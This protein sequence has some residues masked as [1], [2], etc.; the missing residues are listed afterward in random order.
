MNQTEFSPASEVLERLRR[1]ARERLKDSQADLFLPFLDRYYGRIDAADLVARSLPDLFGVAFAHLRLGMARRRGETRLAVYSPNYDEHGFAVPH[2]VIEI[3]TDDMP[4]LVDSVTMELRRHRLGLHAVI[5]PVV[6]VRRG[7]DGELLEVLAEPGGTKPAD[8]AVILESFHHIEVDRQTE[9][10]VLEQLRDDLARVLGDVRAAVADWPVMLDRA[11]SLA[12]ELDSVDAADPDR[13]EIAEFLRWLIDGSFTFLGYREYEVVAVNGDQLLRAVPGTG[14]GV[15]RETSGQPRPHRL[16]TMPPEVRDKI[17]E[18]SLLNLTKTRSLATVHRSRYLDYVGVKRRDS[19]GTA[20]GEARFLGLYTTRVYKQWPSNIPI[21][22]RKVQAVLERAAHPADSHDGKAMVEILDSYP[23]DEL[24]QC[25]EDDLYTDARA[26]LAMR[27]RPRLRLR[28]R[29]DVF[30]RFYSCFVDLP[31]GKLTPAV[32]E[33]IRDALMT[34]LH[35]VHSEESTLLTDAVLARLH[36]VIYAEPGTAPDVDFV[37]I[38]RRIAAALRDWSDDLTD[39]LVEEFGEERGLLLLQRYAGAFPPGYRSDFPARMAVGDIRRI[40]ELA[41]DAGGRRL[42]MHLYRPLESLAGEPRLTLYRCGEPLT[43]SDVLPMLENMGMQVIDQRPYEVRPAGGTSV[44]IYDYGLRWEDDLDLDSGDIRERLPHALAAVWRGDAE[45]DRF[46]RLVLRAG[47]RAHEVTVLRAYAKYL[48][49]TGTTFSQRFM[50]DALAGNPSIVRGLVDLVWTRFDPDLDPGIDRE[51]GEK[52]LVADIVRGIDAVASLNEDRVLR[53]LLGL[54]MATLRTNL[55][56][57][58]ERGMPKEWLSMKLNPREIPDLPLPRPMFEIFVYSPRVEGVHLRGG[59]VARGG[60]RWSDRPEDYRTEVLGLMKAQVVKNAVIVPVGAK[61]G[62]VTKSPPATRE[63]LHAEVIACYRTFVRGLLDVTD[64]LVDGQ[65]VAPQRVV[66]HDGDDPYL[67]V[68]ADKGTATFSDL[69]NEISG[70]YGFWLRDAFAS[71]G[72]VGYDHKAMGITARGAWVS[73]QRHLRALGVDVQNDDVTVAG[74]GDMSGDVFGNGMLLS[75]HIRLIAA[76]DHRHV[77]LDPVPDPERSFAER[78]RLFA[79]ARSS[80]ADYDPELDLTGRRGVPTD[81]EVH[82]ALARGAARA[83]HRRGVVGSRPAHQRHPARPR[84]PAVEWR[85]R[86]LREGLHGD[87]RRGGRQERGRRSGRCRP[88]A[89]P[90]RGRGRKPRVHPARADPVRAAWRAD[91]HRRHRQRGG[92]RLLRPRG[93][94]Q[95]R[96]RSARR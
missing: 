63:E 34:A 49:Q 42:A 52:Q 56:Q 12:L 60:L 41:S 3:V 15:L 28:V 92:R 48:R 71:G 31:F 17:L 69:A 29:R 96:G 22:R 39:A 74:I 76:F 65:V 53:S 13:A 40:E 61:G 89:L 81:C 62:F 88:A 70:E 47:L 73:V 86:H 14:L 51:L 59:E 11:A 16:S 44:W 35:G 75:R 91:Q 32:G 68:A 78:S 95:D 20:I 79:L 5:H 36:Y 26:L 33:R 8:D 66:R 18:P 25:S 93:E 45:N 23:R 67:V 84:R 1:Y 90:R 9:P 4:F 37:V 6:A 50:A 82:R 57:T 10:G 55:F 72:S 21:L 80:W 43:L 19:A 77:F 27:H 94:R 38:E 2:T 85:H 24:F 58:D 30:G 64:N 83:G 87:E 54:V 46:N 7:P